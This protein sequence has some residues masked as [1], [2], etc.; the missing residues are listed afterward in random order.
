[1]SLKTLLPRNELSSGDNVDTSTT[2]S[3]FFSP[4][5]HIYYYELMLS[6]ILYGSTNQMNNNILDYIRHDVK[7]SHQMSLRIQKMANE[8]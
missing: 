1:M 3:R 8:L 6:M 2:E 4:I 7:Y 5:T